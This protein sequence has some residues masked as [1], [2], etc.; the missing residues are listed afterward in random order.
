MELK[1]VDIINTDFAVTPESGQKVF[2]LLNS[3][4]KKGSIAEL[5]F[6]GINTMTTAFLNAAIGQLYSIDEYNSSFLKDHLKPIN[7]TNFQIR[8]MQMVVDGAKK[9]FSNKSKFD[10]NLNDSMN[11]LN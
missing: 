2:E 5:N 7:L 1:I 6:L 11:A 4:F 8:Q 10:S 9:Y 3:Y